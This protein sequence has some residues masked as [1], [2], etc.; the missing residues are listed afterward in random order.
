MLGAHRLLAHHIMGGAKDTLAR[1]DRGGEAVSRIFQ[2]L[3]CEGLREGPVKHVVWAMR[4]ADGRCTLDH[5]V[6]RGTLVSGE[7]LCDRRVIAGVPLAALRR[8]RGRSRLQHRVGGHCLACE[9]LSDD[10]LRT[11]A[12]RQFLLGQGLDEL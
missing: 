7:E 3:A 5:V 9:I 11:T 10:A 1:E 8:Q 12:C 2:T 4:V 6:I